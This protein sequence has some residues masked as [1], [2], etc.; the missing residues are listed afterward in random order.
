MTS[1]DWSFSIFA[2]TN[3]P[4]THYVDIILLYSLSTNKN[5]CYYHCRY[6]QRIALSPWGNYSFR[7]IAR[8]AVGN[9]RPSR[10]TQRVCSTP[11]DVPHHNPKGVCTRN[12]KPHH[13][14]ISWQVSH[15]QHS[16]WWANNALYSPILVVQVYII[17]IK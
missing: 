14:I 1:I 13:L 2:V 7:V 16:T 3:K 17:T 11:P 8:N 6:Y 4:C 10:P 5:H 12:V 15:H 9:S